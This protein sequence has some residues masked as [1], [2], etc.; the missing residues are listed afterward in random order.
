VVQLPPLA[1]YIIEPQRA[2]VVASGHVVLDAR[3]VGDDLGLV[4]GVLGD[5]PVQPTFALLRR[6]A[7]GTW[8]TLWLPQGQRDWIA[9]DGEIAFAGEGLDVLQVSG[10]SF[11]LDEGEDAA[12]SECRACP[13]RQLVADWVRQGDQYVRQTQLPADA[14]L[15]DALWEMTQRTPYG[16]VYECIRRLRLDLPVDELVANASVLAKLRDFGLATPGLRLAPTEEL[17]DR[18]NFAELEGTRR[19]SA[20]VQGGRI[21]YIEQSQ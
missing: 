4:F 1:I 11:G 2:Q 9:T 15:A 10:S 5:G 12:F 18:V 8:Q 16:V 17:A 3:L 7:D 21:I 19:Y 6:Q 20:L 14:P 13:H